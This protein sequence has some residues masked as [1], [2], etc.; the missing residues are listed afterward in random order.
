MDKSLNIPNYSD[1]ELVRLEL[2][3][4]PTPD[5]LHP[6]EKSWRELAKK[7]MLHTEELQRALKDLN[8]RMY[9]NYRFVFKEVKFPEQFKPSQ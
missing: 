5:G 3:Q 2:L 4:Y 6:V 8:P 7:L 1:S 9:E